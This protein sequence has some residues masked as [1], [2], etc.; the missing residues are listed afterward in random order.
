VIKQEAKKP[1]KVLMMVFCFLNHSPAFFRVPWF[2][3][4]TLIFMVKLSPFK[5]SSAAA[6][7]EVGRAFQP[8]K[9]ITKFVP[10]FAGWK[11]R[12]TQIS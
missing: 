3:A 9:S 7:A 2:S 11:T 5:A 10:A 4:K 1:G 6:G 8:G 12:A